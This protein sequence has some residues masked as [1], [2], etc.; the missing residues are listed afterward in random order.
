MLP[1]ATFPDAIDDFEVPIEVAAALSDLHAT[2]LDAF[3]GY[4]VSVGPAS[5]DAFDF[6]SDVT[7]IAGPDEGEVG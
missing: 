7:V 3:V 4:Q 6:G 1:Y 5:D 2:T